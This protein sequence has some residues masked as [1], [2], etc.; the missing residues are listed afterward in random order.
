MTRVFGGGMTAAP[1]TAARLSVLEMD[2]TIDQSM[3][4]PMDLLPLLHWK[5]I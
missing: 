3:F 4:G 2:D 1:A 5:L